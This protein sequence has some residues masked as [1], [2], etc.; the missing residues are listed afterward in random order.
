MTPKTK[1]TTGLPIR[2]VD[3]ECPDCGR[4]VCGYSFGGIPQT[5]SCYGCG[6]LMN[7]YHE[8]LLVGYT[9]PQADQQDN[10]QTTPGSTPGGPGEPVERT[11]E[12]TKT[13]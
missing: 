8:G 13:E 5:I 11:K 4:A 2:T 1:T 6:A 9:D 10:D 3:Y 12:K 7:P